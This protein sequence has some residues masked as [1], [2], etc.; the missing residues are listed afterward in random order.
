M[1]VL[2]A[3]APPHGTS[4]TF[5]SLTTS[6]DNQVSENL[7]TVSWI[8]TQGKHQADDTEIKNGDPFGHDPL[9]IARTM[10]QHGIV[11]VSCREPCIVRRADISLWS[12]ARIHCLDTG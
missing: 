3:D 1:V 9:V 8:G 2:I 12:H 7:E 6:A 10:A 4:F 11:L 5:I